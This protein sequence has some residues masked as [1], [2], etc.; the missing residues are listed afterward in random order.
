MN[1]PLL[2]N[3]DPGPPFIHS[4]FLTICC[5]SLAISLRVNVIAWCDNPYISMVSHPNH[6]DTAFLDNLDLGPPFIHSL[7]FTICCISLAISLRVNLITWCD[8]P[9]I[10]MVS[11]PN[12]MIIAFLDS[13][14]LALPFIH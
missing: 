10:S 2:D 9:Y 6:M 11:H 12:H 13:L 3:L 7:C 8:N 5:I 4:L 14:D 1:I